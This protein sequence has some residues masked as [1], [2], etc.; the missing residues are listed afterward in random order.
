M[1]G[2]IIYSFLYE[3]A[4]DNSQQSDTKVIIKEKPISKKDTKE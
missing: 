3:I 2:N 4:S 1:Y